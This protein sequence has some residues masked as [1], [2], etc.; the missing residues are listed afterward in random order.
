MPKNWVEFSLDGGAALISRSNHSRRF[1]FARVTCVEPQLFNAAVL[2][3]GIRI[4]SFHSR[5]RL[6]SACTFAI[7]VAL[8]RFGS[9]GTGIRH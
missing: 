9:T 3:V 4:S 6:H 8:A 7:Q 2:R 5:H 1:V